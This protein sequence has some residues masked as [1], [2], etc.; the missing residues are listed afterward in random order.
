MHLFLFAGQITRALRHLA[1]D[2]AS[3]ANTEDPKPIPLWIT[4]HSLGAALASLIYARYL[5]Y[6]RDLG[7]GIVLRD[8]YTFGCQCRL[9]DLRRSGSLTPSSHRSSRRRRNICFEV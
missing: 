8:G 3:L 4:G 9:V 5:R 1:A 6:P 7:D 2:L